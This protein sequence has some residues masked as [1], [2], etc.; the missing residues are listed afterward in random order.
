MKQ[1][2]R[3][4]FDKWYRR[5]ET[6]VTS[7]EDLHRKVA[8]VVGVSEEMLQREVRSVLDVGC[9][10]A[11]WFPELRQIRPRVEYIGIDA[12]EYAVARFGRSRNL[13]LGTIGDLA[14]QRFGSSFDVIVCADVLHY[15]SAREIDRGLETLVDLLDGVA[16]LSVFTTDDEPTGDLTGW[17]G[18]TA[19]W[20]RDRFARHGLVACGMQCYA[21]PLLSESATALDIL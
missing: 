12:S 5:Q 14:A 10:E 17:H 19:K 6:R 7:R 21:G 20:Y 2:D 8:M 13:R 16:Y 4:Y 9:G 15:L 3:E 1:Y 18:R 11:R